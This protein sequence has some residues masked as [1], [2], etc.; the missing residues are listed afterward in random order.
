[1]IQR[2]WKYIFCDYARSV[3]LQRFVMIM[4]I[5][6]ITITLG[7]TYTYLR[8]KVRDLKISI[9]ATKSRIVKLEERKTALKASLQTQVLEWSLKQSALQEL[10]M[11]DFSPQRT[12]Q[13][14]W[15][16]SLNEKYAAATN[17]YKMD[18]Q[19]EER[20]EWLVFVLT[21]LA[22]NGNSESLKVN[23]SESDSTQSEIALAE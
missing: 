17:R 12:I 9:N 23:L 3:R 8:F 10:G 2:F 22:M 21:Q 16:N 18:R 19:P 11:V 4:I 5:S 13:A 15:P 7:V 14:Q 1:M 6:L 20:K